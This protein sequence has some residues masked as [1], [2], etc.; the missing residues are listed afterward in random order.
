[1][2]LFEAKSITESSAEAVAAIESLLEQQ[3]TNG[4]LQGDPKTLASRLVTQVWAQQPE[5]YEGRTGPKPHQIA[6][7]AIALAAGMRLEA[8]RNNEALRSSYTFALGL[9]L[10]EIASNAHAY[11][12]H[13]VDHQLLDAAAATFEEPLGQLQLSP[14]FESFGL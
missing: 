9:I 11:A 5:L 10:N 13:H 1:V 2:D 3:V 8:Y 14:L 6:V 7:A 12:F 4:L